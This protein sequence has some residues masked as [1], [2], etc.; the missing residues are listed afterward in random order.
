MAA[1]FE[2]TFGDDGELHGVGCDQQ[3]HRNERLRERLAMGEG[4]AAAAPRAD[5]FQQHHGEC[6]SECL[7]QWSQVAI[8]FGAS[9]PWKRLDNQKLEPQSS[10]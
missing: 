7:C 2:G 8:G 9:R 10:R 3:R 1:C 6:G 5:L 4:L